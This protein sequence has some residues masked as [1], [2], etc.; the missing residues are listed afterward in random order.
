MFGT[1]PGTFTV[2]TPTT[3]NGVMTLT[4]NYSQPM[5]FLFFPGPTVTTSQSKI[6][7]LAPT[8]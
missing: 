7:Y 2:P 4:V 8:A 3:T 1:E 5:N 6:V